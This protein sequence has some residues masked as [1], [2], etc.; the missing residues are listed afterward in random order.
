M[1]DDDEVVIEAIAR[2]FSAA[3]KAWG[4][5]AQVLCGRVRSRKISFFRAV[6]MTSL[7]Y[8]FG[9]EKSVVCRALRRNPSHFPAARRTVSNRLDQGGEFERFYQLW[10]LALRDELK[11]AGLSLT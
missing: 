10:M 3:E 9:L 8:D 2:A 4:L 11:L 1:S 6:V 7:V 5:K